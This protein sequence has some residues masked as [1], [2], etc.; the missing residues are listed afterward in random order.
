MS[1]SP[2]SLHHSTGGWSSQIA[3]RYACTLSPVLA[4]W[5]DGEL[6]K[7]A[8][9]GEY[10]VPVSP[11]SLLSSTPDVIWPGLMNC[12]LLPLIGNIAGDWLCARVD[13]NNVLSEMVQWYHGGGDWIPWGSDLSQAIFFDSVNER[14]S[15]GVRRHAVPA[16]ELRP[17]ADTLPR[18]DDVWLKWAI[19]HLPSSFKELHKPSVQ[20]Q[21]IA[22]AMLEAGVAETAVCCELVIKQLTHWPRKELEKLFLDDASLDRSRLAPW[23]FDLDLVPET[24]QAR[25]RQQTDRTVTQDSVTQDWD[26]ASDHARRVCEI[27]PEMAWSWE[28]VGYAAERQ[29]DVPKAMD[30]YRRAARCSVFTDQSTRLDSHWMETE[31]AKFSVARIAR[32]RPEEVAQSPYLQILCEADARQR[33]RRVTEYWME[34]AKSLEVDQNHR[35][36]HSCY[37]AAGWDLGA[38]LIS[39]YAELLDR[40]ADQ[41][42]I[43]GQL[44]RAELAR[45]HRQCLRQRYGC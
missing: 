15:G 27:A 42:R 3:D 7:L 44:G 20:G 21:D 24:I 10:R 34:K 37:L 36:A 19:S 14:I 5:F 22:D 45:T 28:I 12:E 38:D 11:E 39:G 43:T 40:I 8:G 33:R 32:I 18:N 41:A 2:H 31:A 9:I 23:S 16:E 6:W 30:A 4:D 17:P 1:E 29:N 13:E 26:A 35:D 25:L